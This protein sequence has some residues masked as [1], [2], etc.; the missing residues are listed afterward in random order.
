M[1]DVFNPLPL[2]I[3]LFWQDDIAKSR[4]LNQ[5]FLKHL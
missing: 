2:D 5:T 1:Q 4:I 3:Y